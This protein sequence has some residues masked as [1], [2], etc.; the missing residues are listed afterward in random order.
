[1]HVFRRL[2][3]YCV[4][5]LACLHPFARASDWDK[6]TTVNIN[7]RIEVP[8]AV[9]EPGTYVL[10]LLDSSSNR[11]IVEFMNERENHL[12]SLAFA[13]PAYRT[14]PTD[15]TVLTFYE[16]PA[17]QPEALRTWFYPG[18]SWGQ[19]FTYHGHPTP[20]R[21]SATAL[22]VPS[23]RPELEPIGPEKP[24]ELGPV[25]TTVDIPALRAQ[26]PQT[27]AQNAPPPSPSQEAAPAL[28][29]APQ[30]PVP[31]DSSLPRTASR[32]PAIALFGLAA[33]VGAI[34]LRKLA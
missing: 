22:A 21:A 3:V 19:E 16:A 18:D 14:L 11:H 17:G 8:G 30:E 23:P 12:Y 31:S 15:K 6:K 27:L 24:A 29:P 9:L 28:E 26:E 5:T 13:V 1:M 25:S 34:A 33:L 2:P 10:K 4:L 20:L 32:A 7:R